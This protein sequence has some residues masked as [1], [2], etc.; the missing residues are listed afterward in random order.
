MR[1]APPLRPWAWKLL[2]FSLLQCA[3]FACVLGSAHGAP[4]WGCAGA[5]AAWGV[6]MALVPDPRGEIRLALLSASMGAVCETVN[7]WSDAVLVSSDPVPPPFP[8]SWLVVLWAVF[9]MVLRHSASWLSGRPLT[10]A[11]CGAIAGPLSWHGGAALGGVTLGDD[12]LLSSGLL[13]LEWAIVLP[14][15]VLAA[16][17]GVRGSGDRP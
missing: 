4:V 16:D 10:A 8:P 9:P 14:V 2:N 15:L 3:W 7:R 12:P 13:S 1:P 11:A 5:A 17:R 6:H